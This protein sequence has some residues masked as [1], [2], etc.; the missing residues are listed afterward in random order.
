MKKRKPDWAE[1]VASQ[2]VCLH[3]DAISI[4]GWWIFGHG[5]T[6]TDVV[7]IT[8]SLA[9]ALRKAKAGV[10]CRTYSF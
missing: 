5:Y 9:S 1:R 6:E 8:K 3:Y 4:A 10:K 7:R 2:L